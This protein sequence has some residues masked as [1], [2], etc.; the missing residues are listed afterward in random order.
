MI[1]VKLWLCIW[2]YLYIQTLNSIFYLYH[3]SN[4]LSLDNVCL[5]TIHFFPSLSLCVS[6][7]PAIPMY[8]ILLYTNWILSLLWSYYIV[9]LYSSG[10]R[11]PTPTIFNIKTFLAEIKPKSHTTSC[12]TDDRWFFRQ[13]ILMKPFIKPYLFIRAYCWWVDQ[14][15][16]KL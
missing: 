10:T 5:L 14:N 8:T 16:P 13:P 12:L 15:S 6:L 7:L 4:Y 9:I 11:R 3:F 1:I 2:R